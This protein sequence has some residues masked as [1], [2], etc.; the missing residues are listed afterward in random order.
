MP[1]TPSHPVPKSVF[2]GYA[3]SGAFA[4]AFQTAWYQA[5]VD[6]LGAASLT[7]LVVMTAF[8]GG[9]GAGS[10]FSSHVYSWAD[11]RFGGHG[12]VNYGRTE[13]LITLSVLLLYVAST[14][15]LGPV[16]GPGAYR[17]GSALAHSVRVPSVLYFFLRIALPFLSIGVPCFGMGLTFPYLCSLYKQSGT[18][19][20]RLYAANTAGACVAVLASEFYLLRVI[21]YDGTLL[22]AC[23]GT[24]CLGLFF[25]RAGPL[26]VHPVPRPDAAEAPASP[27]PAFPAIIS[28]LLCGGLQGSVFVFLRLTYGPSRGAFALLSFFAILGIFCAA[29]YVRR[30]R[31]HRSTLVL[32][33]W[34]SIAWC[35]TLWMMEPRLSEAVIRFGSFELTRLFP[36]DLAAGLTAFLYTGLIIFFPYAGF[37]TVL[38]HTCDRIQEAGGDVSAAYALNT[39]SFLTGL[40]L[41]GWVLQYVNPFYAMRVFGLVALASLVLL[42]LRSWSSPLPGKGAAT[43]VAVAGL[44]VLAP[45]DLDM[46]LLA[47]MGSEPYRVL[48]SRSSPQQ[49]MWVRENLPDK[50]RSLM[51]DRFSMSGTRFPGSIYM[52]TMAHLPLLLHEAPREAL[53]IC[54]GVGVTADSI[55]KHPSIEKL[56]IVD[57]NRDVFSL[58]RFFDSTN[59]NVL[60]DP[61]IR[62][63]WDDGRQFLRFPGGLY[64]FVT[65]E[66]PPPLHPG[67]AR[68]YSLEFYE[69]IKSRLREGGFVSQWLPEYQ[70]NEEG[71][72]MI[73]STFTE[74]FP[75]AFLFVGIERELVLVGRTGPISFSGFPDAFER[76]QPSVRRDFE[77]SGQKTSAQ[78]LSRV[79]QTKAALTRWRMFRVIQD[80]FSSLDSIELGPVQIL[81]PRDSFRHPKSARLSFDVEGTIRVFREQRV[82]DTGEVERILS[83]PALDPATRATVPAWYFPASS[84]TRP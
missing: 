17:E 82:R 55:R 42:G 27:L 62:L 51:F 28:G 7:F 53:L 72:G 3:F 21:G 76:A 80:G 9:L 20:S 2:V 4:L 13:L 44:S 43:F 75:D 36:T 47:G 73:I 35:A 66:P 58:N 67:I 38:P 69:S 71:V 33:C 12:L 30:L 59:G 22:L 60:A 83:N 56:D 14:I 64:D 50:S 46:K 15:P 24:L 31:P 6:R 74:A 84:Q 16:L 45:R 37:S 26:E 54:F 68:L 61:R 65:M 19:P 39:I 79:M 63:F 52:R 8:I 40:V 10:Y 23:A 49:F 5:F 48:E 78:V 32:L 29:V 70:M 57:L 77:S 18:F 81:A 11:R 41:F 34:A 1:S 25:M